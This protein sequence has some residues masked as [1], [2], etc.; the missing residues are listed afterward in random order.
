MENINTMKITVLGVIGVVGG[1]IANMLGGWDMLLSVLLTLMAIDYIMGIIV[2][3]VFHTSKKSATG[4]L[5]SK[6]G[7]K[8]LCKKGVTLLIVLVT[9]QVDNVTGTQTV[10]NGAV[11]FYI[12]NEL[13]SITE[14]ADAM[15]APIPTILKKAIGV[16]QSKTEV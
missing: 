15:G 7:W 13:I 1:F 12:A 2:A 10:R 11:I 4:A 16:F 6:A 3:G 14:N 5:D 8:G 9:V